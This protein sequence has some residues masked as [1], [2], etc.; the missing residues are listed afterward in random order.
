MIRFVS[1]NYMK[2]YVFRLKENRISQIIL[3]IENYFTKFAFA[4]FLFSFSLRLPTFGVLF[5]V[6]SKTF[7]SF[8]V[9][10]KR[11]KNYGCQLISF[12]FRPHS[13]ANRNHMIFHRKVQECFDALKWQQRIIYIGWKTIKSTTKSV[14]LSKLC[15]KMAEKDER[16]NVRSHN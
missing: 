13:S 2:L 16:E 14:W 7:K 9:K 15:Q 11:N 4:F 1:Q 6:P 12:L 8:S 5:S 10:Q 3:S